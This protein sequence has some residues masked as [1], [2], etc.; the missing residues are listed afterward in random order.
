[1]WWV[2]KLKVV[3]KMA[4]WETW[5]TMSRIAMHFL[6]VADCT[7]TLS[8]LFGTRGPVH[9]LSF[10][11]FFLLVFKGIDSSLLSDFLASLRYLLLTAVMISFMSRWTRRGRNQIPMVSRRYWELWLESWDQMITGWRQMK[12][13]MMVNMTNSVVRISRFSFLEYRWRILKKV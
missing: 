3:R 4:S 5:M 8:F 7:G 11:P 9:K 12:G 1:M 2:I 6:D 10:F 13:W